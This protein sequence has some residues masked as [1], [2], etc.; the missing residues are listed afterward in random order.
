M[1]LQTDPVVPVVPPGIPS[2][3]L[4]RRPDIAAAERAWNDECS[5]DALARIV[6]IKAQLSSSETIEFPAES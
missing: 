1:A 2:Q 5:E 4:L 3:L 6:E